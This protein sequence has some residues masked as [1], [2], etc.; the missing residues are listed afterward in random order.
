MNS[1]S[2]GPTPA[3]DT[4]AVV[5][6]ILRELSPSGAIEIRPDTELVAE[7]GFDSLGLVELLVALEDSLDLPPIDTETPIKMDSVADLEQIVLK[8]QSGTL[9]N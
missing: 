6:E 2:S 5:L 8:A 9:P 7:L 4:G 1:R 3:I